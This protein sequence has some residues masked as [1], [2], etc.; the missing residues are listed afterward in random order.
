MLRLK[1]AGLVAVIC[2]M[3]LFA[4]ARSATMILRAASASILFCTAAVVATTAAVVTTEIR[5]RRA[6]R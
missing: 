2:A 5:A 4:V 6:V 3:I 1:L